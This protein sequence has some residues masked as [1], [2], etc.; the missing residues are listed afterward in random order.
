[1]PNDL[2]HRHLDEACGAQVQL[3][4]AAYLEARPFGIGAFPRLIG[5]SVR[6]FVAALEAVSILAA[7]PQLTRTTRWGWPVQ[8]AIAFDARTA[9]LAATSLMRAR[10]GAQ[11]YQRSPR[12]TGCS[13]RATN[14]ATTA[15]S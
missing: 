7:G 9:Q 15:P 13:P 14:N 6:A 5:F 4:P 2:D 3:G 1:M 12:M 8:D 11:A 10:K